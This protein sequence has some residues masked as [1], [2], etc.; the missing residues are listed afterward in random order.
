[1]NEMDEWFDLLQELE[2]TAAL[3]ED[4][5]S[6]A[7]HIY[8]VMDQLVASKKPPQVPPQGHSSPTLKIKLDELGEFLSGV[9]RRNLNSAYWDLHHA[10]SVID[11]TLER[12]ASWTATVELQRP[13]VGWIYVW[14]KRPSQLRAM[15]GALRESAVA[16]NVLPWSPP[17]EPNASLRNIR[18]FRY[19]EGDKC[20]AS[21]PFHD[22]GRFRLLGER[23]PESDWGF[24]VALCPLRGTFHPHFELGEGIFRVK[25]TDPMRDSD[26]LASHLTRVIEQAGE[27]GI[28]LLVFPELTI[29]QSARKH[30]G[31]LLKRSR[32]QFPYGVVAGSFHI[33]KGEGSSEDGGP[34]FNESLLLERSSH[35]LTHHK[36]GA[37]VLRTR[38]LDKGFFPDASSN[39][40]VGE[41]VED[42]QRGWRLEFLETRFGSMAVLIC[43]D[44]TDPDAEGYVG[45]VQKLRPDLLVVVSMS[46]ETEEFQAKAQEMY[47]YGLG[48][49]IVNASCICPSR[50]KEGAT[51]CLAMAHLG[52]H[53]LPGA[54]PVFVRWRAD[55]STV[56]RW[57][58]DQQPKHWVEVDLTQTNLVSWLDVAE[59]KAGLVL[60]FG[61]YQQWVKQL[62]TNDF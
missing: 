13:L 43:A 51:P 50:A 17:P 46:N 39:D 38:V 6:L 8:A 15:Q 25:R 20:T 58:Y 4:Y 33:W 59:E 44:L 10:L 48:T 54:P 5:V 41:L 26:L 24:R 3:K 22:I 47:K 28:H 29:D 53:Q 61:V 30:I 34:P 35:L 55:N 1:M 52:L 27:M 23:L 21:M 14:S 45:V 42:I 37:F 62:I 12:G 36:R 60:D 9:N 19:R 31:L 40:V 11:G 2:H 7:A 56:E 32:G 49:L 57:S 16:S 18:L